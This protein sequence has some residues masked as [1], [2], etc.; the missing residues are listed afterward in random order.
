M[1]TSRHAY[2]FNSVFIGGLLL[3][4]LNDHILKAAYGNVLTGK[5]SDFAGVLILP[6]L[7]R[8]VTGRS[9]L[10]CIGLTVW[11]FTWWKSPLSQGAIDLVNGLTSLHWVR[12]V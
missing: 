1:T 6:L 12:V 8:F 2:L 7:L 5:L 3:L 10:L 11:F 4:L 9:S